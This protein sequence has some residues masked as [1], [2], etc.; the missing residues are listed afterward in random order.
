MKV[1]ENRV[2]CPLEVPLDFNAWNLAW[3]SGLD[4]TGKSV[5]IVAGSL[6]NPVDQLNRMVG[7]TE[8]LKRLTNY[9]DFGIQKHHKDGRKADHF[10]LELSPEELKGTW[11]KDVAEFMISQTWT[12]KELDS[13]E[14]ELA[15]HAWAVQ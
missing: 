11:Q 13:L 2:G 14:A 4:Y 6:L 7:R 15:K 10:V 8:A 3:L 9:L 1:A 12:G 5:V